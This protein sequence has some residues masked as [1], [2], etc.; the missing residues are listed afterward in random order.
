M[1]Y[2]TK[3]EIERLR[4]RNSLYESTGLFDTLVFKSLSGLFNFIAFAIGAWL[5]FAVF[6][7]V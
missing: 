1:K 2:L 4:F 7:G 3:R 5:F 6:F